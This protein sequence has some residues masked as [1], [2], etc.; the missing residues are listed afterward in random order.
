[1][2]DAVIDD[3]VFT[4]IAEL[5]EDSLGEFI[6]T[7]LENSPKLITNMR[8]A[9][10]EAD[11]EKIMVNAHQLKGGSGSMGAMQVFAITKQ[12]EADAKDQKTDD[13]QR[14][15]NELEAAYKQVELKLKTH[16]S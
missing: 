5:M 13:L 3:K 1:M 6:E 12:L 15:F 4:E 16:L 11:T 8:N 9:L 14:L 10:N 7:Y 2:T